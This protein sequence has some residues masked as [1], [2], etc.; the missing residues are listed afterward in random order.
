MNIV[1]LQ[2]VVY[3]EFVSGDKP[4]FPP[5]LAAL[6]LATEAA[7]IAGATDGVG[8]LFS[9]CHIDPLIRAFS[10]EAASLFEFVARYMSSLVY[11][12]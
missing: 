3:Y 9:A 2:L 12:V 11:N 5:E 10:Q 1:F 7:L 8:C 6:E 4:P